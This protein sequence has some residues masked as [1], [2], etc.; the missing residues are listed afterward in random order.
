MKI[1]QSFWSGNQTDFT[2]NYGWYSYKYNWL[3][4]ILSCHQLV[5]YH[6]EVELYTDRFGYEILIKKLQLPYTKVHVVLDELNHYNK[7]LWAIAK[8]RTF[9]LQTEPFIHID[10]D[11]F[12]WDSLMSKFENSNLIAQNLEITTDYY[13]ERWKA[14]FPQLL[15]LPNEMNDYNENKSNLACNMGIIGGKNLDFF[16]I[17]TKKSIEFVDKNKIDFDS[18]D[19]LNFNIFFEQVFFKELS[20]LTKQNIDFLFSEISL[21]NDYKG[22][23]DF[24]KVPVKSYLHLLGTYKR[25]PT[26]CKAMEIYLMRHYPESYSRLSKLINEENKNNIEIEFLNTEKV[27]EILIEFDFEI[28][29]NI[30]KTG[31]F[32]LKRDLY[33]VGSANKLDTYLIQTQNFWIVTLN[34]FER[35]FI[36]NNE[37]KVDCLIIEEINISSR[38]Y[39]LDEIDDIIL[40]EITKPIKYFDFIKKIKKYL[41]EDDN[42]SVAEFIFLINQRLRNYLIL[43]IIS[44]YN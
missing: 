6:K 32:L 40:S 5:K 38:I 15:F 8:I 3:S 26:V 16:K 34:G 9:Q 24:D 19:A 30:F 42:D 10:G 21:D 37:K 36:I 33:N 14:I 31:H 11:V 17:Y 25:N 23:G 7:N 1:V 41:E 44:I 39:D 35:K 12:V 27:T 13:R 29:A 2:Y 4:W 18:F 20:N 28:K 43:K 22:F